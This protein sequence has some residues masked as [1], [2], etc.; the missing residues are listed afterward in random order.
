MATSNGR[1]APFTKRAGPAWS[2]T[3]SCGV[4]R[5]YSGSLF[6]HHGPGPSGRPQSGIPTPGHD[7]Y[8]RYCEVFFG[9]PWSLLLA[10]GPWKSAR[11]RVAWR[12]TSQLEATG[13]WGSTV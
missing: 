8:W 3:P 2:P 10:V 4:P 7:E 5:L 12:A 1:S 11:V 13:S 9:G 6:Q